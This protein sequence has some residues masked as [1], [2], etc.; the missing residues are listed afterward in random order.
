[1][2]D[3]QSLIDWIKS[4]FDNLLGSLGWGREAA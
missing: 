4:T 2:D 3:L 1:M